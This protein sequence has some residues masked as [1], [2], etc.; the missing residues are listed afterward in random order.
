[1]TLPEALQLY[2]AGADYVVVPM[3]LTGEKML[4]KARMLVDGKSITEIRDKEI[5]KLI[6][7]VEKGFMV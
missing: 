4:K 5:E 1:M 2:K 6:K 7:E 3:R